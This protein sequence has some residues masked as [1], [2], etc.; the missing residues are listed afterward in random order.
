MKSYAV[1]DIGTLKVKLQVVERQ[2]SG[3]L[4]TVYS[5]NNLTCLGCNMNENLNRPKKEN[6]QKTINELLRCKKI[7]DDH[8]IKK[9]RVVSTHALREM[10]QVGKEIAKEIKKKTGFK[11]EIISQQEEAELFYQAVLRDFKTDSNLT[12]IDVGGGSVQI[13]VGNTKQLKHS[14]LLKTG[15]STLWDMFTPSHKNLDFPNRDE[16]RKMKEYILQQIQP[17]PSDLKT[18]IVYGSSCIIDLFRGISV[19][20]QKYN[21][22]PSHPY[23]VKISD[24]EK[25]LE[26]VWEIPYDVREEKFVSPTYKY[27]WGVDKAFLNVIELARKIQAPYIIP[28]NANIAQ[29][30]I[31]S[32]TD[33]AGV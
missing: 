14:F 27:M 7:L 19:P 16:I 11:V 9:V 26:K 33:K 22:S 15:T 13:L 3:S 17:V 6:I 4:K 32:M 1:I 8:K 12:I 21:F 23:K 28:S 18:P 10:G 31:Y 29:G 30:F 20:M 25:F 2:S 5:S 24:M